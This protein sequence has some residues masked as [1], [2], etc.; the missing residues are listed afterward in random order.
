MGHVDF[1]ALEA[2]GVVFQK[3]H[4]LIQD[5]GRTVSGVRD[6]SGQNWQLTD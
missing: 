1:W 6:Y 3:K 4:A 2:Q 5:T